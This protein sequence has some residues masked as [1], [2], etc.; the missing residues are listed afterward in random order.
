MMTAEYV[1]SKRLVLGI[2]EALFFLRQ[3]SSRIYGV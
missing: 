2:T 3:I 1:L